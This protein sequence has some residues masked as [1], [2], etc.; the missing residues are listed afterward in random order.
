MFNGIEKPGIQ[1][2]NQ[3][4]NDETVQYNN[5]LNNSRVIITGDGQL[6]T[7]TNNHECQLKKVEIWLSNIC[8]GLFAEEKES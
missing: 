1:F 6:W 7:S 5:K 2:Q 3:E 8:I 4:M